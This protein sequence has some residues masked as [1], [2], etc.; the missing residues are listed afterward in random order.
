MTILIIV[1][2]VIVLVVVAVFVGGYNGLVRLRN[3]IDAAWAQ[4]DVQLKR[5]YDLIPNLVETVKGYAAHEN[6]DLRGGDPGPQRQRSRQSQGPG[7][8]RRGRE[9]ADRDAQVAVRRGRGLPGP[10]GQRRTSWSCRSELTDTEDKIAY[11]RQFYNDT[12]Q[13]LQHQHPVDPDQHHRRS[14]P[15]REAGVLRGRR[16]LT[17]SGQGLVLVALATPP[18]TPA[19]PLPEG[20]ALYD[21]VK[22]NKRRSARC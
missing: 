22:Q 6:G 20:P 16:R 1:L 12:V 2:V 10:E 8:R 13:T 5:R 19:P 3:Q 11:A 4:I 15:L 18:S 9:R 21:Q 14:L 7:R 17:R